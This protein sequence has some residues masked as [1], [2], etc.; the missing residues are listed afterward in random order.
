MSDLQTD[1]DICAQEPIQV[2][3]AIQPFGALVVL[4]PST[5]RVLHRS[6]NASAVL[7]VSPEI[8]APLPMEPKLLA[9]LSAWMSGGQAAYARQINLPAGRFQM[10]ASRSRQGLLLSFEAIAE[11]PEAPTDP[12]YAYEQLRRFIDRIEPVSDVREVGHIVA[13]Q[14]RAMTGFNRTLIY[15][16]DPDWNGTVIAEDGDGTLPSYLDLRFPASDIP[17]QARA[18]YQQ[19]RLRLIPD[20]DYTPVPV[21]PSVSPIDGEKL[22]LADVALRSV[23]PVHL[24]YMRNMATQASM[25]ISLVTDGR[26]WGL[27]SCHHQTPRH[28]SPRIRSACDFLGQLVAQQIS[29][30]ERMAEIGQRIALKR[31][32]TE[33]LV[34]VARTESFHAGLIANPSLWLSLTGATGA[35]VVLADQVRT[36]GITPSEA[37]IRD[38][39]GWL[40][41]GPNRQIFSTDSLSLHW[42]PAERFVAE[43]SGVLAVSISQL[44]PS[45]I[46]WFRRELVR[47][48]TWAG[49]PR[50]PS[51]PSHLS[52]RSS[53]DQ[54]KELVRGKAQPWRPSE[55]ETANDFRT[56]IIDFVLRRAEERAQMTEKLELSN[57]ELEAFSYS[58]SHDLRAPFRH[59]VGYS[60][61][62]RD[63]ESGLDSTSRRYLDTI[64]DAALS[65]GR[66]V[67]DLLAFSQLNRTSLIMGR[68]DMNK[69]VAEARASVMFGVRDR[70]IDWHIATLPEG[71]GDPTMLR[72]ALLN[73]LSNAVKYTGQRQTAVIEVDAYRDD[74]YTVYIVRDNGIGFDMRYVGKLFGVFQRLHR[75][76][77]FEGTGIGLALTKRVIDRHG[78]WI[79]AEAVLDQ[80]A[81]FTFALPR[82]P[83]ETPVA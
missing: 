29:G 37:Q 54:W 64:R 74:A 69:L 63:R 61:L 73:L 48:V 79:K 77:D 30:R 44:H 41:A 80:G 8:D 83:Q 19:N 51:D 5:L 56:A 21:E 17:A 22:N 46:I 1:L 42:Q 65:A 45:Y 40:Q 12:A 58:V 60:E 55:V 32:E 78:G 26:L 15:Q 53:F 36:A 3:G 59:I 25:S 24:R 70:R 39:A 7:G 4:E 16:F 52:P 10:D 71:W 50:K 43:A 38:L 81:T 47:T 67:D 31:V 35:A 23:S 11:E 27:I 57:K 20:A 72:Q 18:L 33:L 82:R 28:I 9:D 66:L 13:Q 49:D 34:K 14:V 62:L 6:A 2:P 75:V 68:V 76:E